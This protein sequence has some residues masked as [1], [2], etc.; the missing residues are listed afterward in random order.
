MSAPRD[1]W[2][3][4]C[5]LSRSFVDSHGVVFFAVIAVQPNQP[6]QIEPNNPTEIEEF[7]GS[8]VHSLQFAP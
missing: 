1:P 8:S 7:D 2:G 6:N 3:S 5:G 4:I